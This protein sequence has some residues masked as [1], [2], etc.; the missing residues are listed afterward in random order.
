MWRRVVDYLESILTVYL[1]SVV[2]HEGFHLAV[3][4]LLGGSGAIHLQCVLLF[5]VTGFV[6][7]EVLLPEAVAS[8]GYPLVYLSGGL[9]TGLLL[10]WSYTSDSDREDRACKFVLGWIH[11]AYSF[12]EMLLAWYPHWVYE[13]VS[14]AL[15]C[16][17]AGLSTLYVLRREYSKYPEG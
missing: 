13:W 9:L 10:L 1:S 12:A 17:A 15:V 5:W 11:L 16:I 8:W 6:E 4:L 2:M 7:W 3:I 14:L